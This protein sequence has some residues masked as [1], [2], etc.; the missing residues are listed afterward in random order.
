MIDTRE[1]YPGLFAAMSQG[2]LVLTVNK[3]LSRSL[4]GGYDAWMVAAGRAAWSTPELFSLD[5]WMHRSLGRLD[6]D[7]GLL[8]G[9]GALWLWEKV[10]EQDIAGSE[11]ALLQ[12]SATARRAHEAHQL[13]VEYGGSLAG[14]PLSDDHQA[15][16]RWRKGYLEACR[17]GGWF[18]LAELPARLCA[19]IAQ[20]RLVI[21]EMVFLAGFDELSPGILQLRAAMEAA[22]ARVVEL[23]AEAAEGG[24]LL[25][26]ACL[27]SEDEVRRAACWARQL[28]ESGAG[29]IGVVVAD[30]QQRRLLVERVFR[31]EIDPE[32]VLAL[33]EQEDRF[34]LSLG[35][36]LEE[37][38][39][40]AAAL[41]IIGSG[42]RLSLDAVSFLLRSPYLA[43]SQRESGGRARFDQRLRSKRQLAFSSSRLQALLDEDRDSDKRPLLPEFTRIIKALSASSKDGRKRLLGE[44]VSSF[45]ELLVAVGWPG[46]RALGS[47]EFQVLKAWKENLLTAV[48]ALEAVSGPVDRGEAVALLRRLAR[49]TTFQPE[50]PAGPLQV[51]GLLEAAG[52][53]FEHLWVLGM[54]DDLVPAPA[55]PNPFIP[56]ALQVARNMP[57]ASAERELEFARMVVAR[58]SAAAPTVIFSHP[59]KDGDVELRPSSLIARLDEGEQAAAASH[60]PLAAMRQSP[61]GLESLADEL[62]PPL[63]EAARA[64]GG[65]GLLK[66]QALCPFRAFAH[67]RLRARALD[68]PEPGLDAGTRGSL[69]HAVLENFWKLTGDQAGLLALSDAQLSARI[70]QAAGEALRQHF[71][72][73]ADQ[74][75]C[76]I[77]GARLCA[78]VRE[79][80]EEVEK[81]RAP[82]SVA[83]I[84]A[85]R[86]VV[87]GG[88]SIDTKV[89]RIDQLNDG[90]RVIIDYK[91]GRVDVGDLLGERLLEPQLPVYGSEEADAELAGVV[92]A[93]VRR[94]ECGAKGVAAE[95]ELLP[96]LAAFAGSK[97]AEKAGIADWPALLSRW[98]RQLAELGDEFARGHA[99]VDPVDFT[100]ACQ[101]CDLAGLCRIDENAMPTEEAE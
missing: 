63:A 47:L 19:A 2:A 80:L 4:R 75:L 39:L 92:F 88:I 45:N 50:S 44:W 53:Q 51:V 91:T 89:D 62:G 55:R 38:G 100:K 90:R 23:V 76:R 36:S 9:Q 13:L 10:I 65:T 61:A 34:S 74:P 27:D 78:L 84:E 29:R 41:E 48:V 60:A 5:A 72:D 95:A 12:V 68:R 37:Q 1:S 28:M 8:Q 22:G 6:E 30:L 56:L 26:V 101:Y 42:H 79:W 59:R 66:D 40:V 33:E 24:T 32:A 81:E 71:G 43:A 3:R 20:G 86:T 82:F 70:E 15:F 25:R 46:E 77:E 54:T 57:H 16:L 49:E 17:K 96:K 99:A 7:A 35:A 64:S 21:P 52:L 87:C 73:E 98:R 18:D 14:L 85:E 67:H 97:G 93:G 83:Q 69:L 58:L 31:E 11:I 94:G